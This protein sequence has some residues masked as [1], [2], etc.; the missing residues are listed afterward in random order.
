[1]S[2]EHSAAL[3]ARLAASFAQCALVSYEQ[4]NLADKFGEIMLGNMEARSC[5]LE[6]VAACASLDAQRD[7][8]AA[9]GLGRLCRVITMT[10]FYHTRMDRAERERI[11]AIEFLTRPSCSS[12]S[13][14]TTAW[15]SAPTLRASP[16]SLPFEPNSYRTDKR[17]FLDHDK[18]LFMLL[19]KMILGPKKQSFIVCS[20]RTWY[21]KVC[22]V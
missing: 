21:K 22:S 15:P 1:M 9:A 20:N 19:C 8:L 16:T 14:T 11:E 4:A 18:F 7:R 3:L 17:W 12:S 5:R 2:A 13:W 10:D 6:G